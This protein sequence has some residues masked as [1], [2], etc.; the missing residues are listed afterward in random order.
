MLGHKLYQRLSGRYEVFGTVRGDFSSVSAS[1]IFEESS[2]IPQI[3][4]TEGSSVKKALETVRPDCVINAVG[5]VKQVPSSSDTIQNLLLNAVFPQRLL[6]LSEAF[7][8]RL[9][10]ISTDC[11]FDGKRGNYSE[12]DVADARDVYGLTKF[13]GEVDGKN[14][15]TIR[16]SIIGRELNSQHSLLEW[17]ISNRGKAVKG[18]VNAIYSGFPTIV[19]ADIISGLIAD[20]PLLTGLYHVASDPISKFDLLTLVNEEYGLGID[21]EPDKDYVIDRSLDPT[22]F[23]QTI[24]FTS[25][26]WPEM[27]KKMA[28]DPTPYDKWH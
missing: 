5:L 19:L 20:H 8:Y 25:A 21:L 24:N 10:S 3:D 28:G 7:G 4:A 26:A 9:I 17:F 1:G 15:L 12:S 13:L 18:Y 6:E 2:I 16:T 11:V 27:I 23:R 22:R 14:A